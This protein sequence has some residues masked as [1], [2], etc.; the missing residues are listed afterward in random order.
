MSP[1]TSL[2]SSI[3]TDAQTSVQSDN[4]STAPVE[5][6]TE[7][8]AESS[9]AQE[10]QSSYQL[11]D[12]SLVLTAAY[13]PAINGS[14]DGQPFA[15]GSFG[16]W[17]YARTLVQMDH[18]WRAGDFFRLGLGLSYERFQG[19]PATYAS[20]LN[21]VSL[22][23]TGELNLATLWGG[24]PV[25]VFD[26]L[27]LVLRGGAGF[28]TTTSETAILEDRLGPA[29]G[30][31]GQL[32][33]VTV[34]MGPVD[35]TLGISA[36]THTT[37]D[38]DDTNNALNYVNGFL[39]F[40]TSDVNEVTETPDPYCNE[41]FEER[42]RADVVALAG[43]EDPDNPSGNALLREQNDE[44]RS[45]LT[46][47]KRQMEDQGIT[48]EEII[49][50]MRQAYV[51]YLME[52]EESPVEDADEAM[53][54]AE[55]RF[56]DDFDPFAIEEVDQVLL[57]DP[58]PEDCDELYGLQRQL[59]DERALLMRQKGL[60]E[61]LT[62][63]ALIRLGA[64]PEAAPEM[65][66]TVTRLQEIHFMTNRPFGAQEIG[67]RRERRYSQAADIRTLDAAVESYLQSHAANEDG[68]RDALGTSQ[69]EDL[70]ASV[71]PRTRRADGGEFYSPSLE[72][73]HE[74]ANSLNSE[75]MRGTS[76]YVVGHTDSRGPRDHNLGL[77]QRRARA[78]R[79]ALILFG[80]SPD[81][82]NPIGRGED[83]PV[84]YYDRQT[85][86]SRAER[87]NNEP[88]RRISR[89]ETSMLRED[90]ITGPALR[91]EVRGRQT[92]N[93]RIEMFICFP[94][95]EDQVC[96]DLAAEVQGTTQEQGSAPEQTSSDSQVQQSTTHPDSETQGAGGRRSSR[97]R[98]ARRAAAASRPVGAQRAT[99]TTATDLPLP[100]PPEG[101]DDL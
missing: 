59:Q 56:P 22:A 82:I 18:L 27:R 13:G 6:S 45:F 10:S 71:F 9:Q 96:T 3:S 83:R 73:I 35:A 4:E 34:D 97:P 39:S 85:G 95:T 70:F 21:G 76:I 79:D 84:Y 51:D 88:N 20:T 61:G 92:T 28:G 50:D 11:S 41:D 65:I 78:I 33:V 23:A 98:R 2:N 90:G 17:D 62:Y 94:E 68:I 91:D 19:E 72:V 5:A 46:A 99:K 1:P 38:I 69:A 8:A 25:R 40:R 32:G 24:S 52:R 7:V 58:L 49:G 48:R 55:R 57:P 75:S 53:A 47:L 31:E 42:I 16:G 101:D 30:L 77:S 89:E 29:F 44:M 63:A 80:V 60:L 81:R 26:Q 74:L 93:R 64:S 15:I 14:D 37:W 43:T 36:G 67:G 12:N 87:Q 54:L 86:L 66:R 100:E